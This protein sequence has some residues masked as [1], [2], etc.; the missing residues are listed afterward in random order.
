[1]HYIEVP[2]TS[3]AL[4]ADGDAQGYVTV[5]SNANFYPGATAWLTSNT[6]P[7]KYCKI[8]DLSGAT[9]I[10]LRF[11]NE[12]T[13]SGAFVGPS[14]IRN[15]CAAYLVADGARIDMEASVVPVEAS[16]SKKAAI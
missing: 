7:A 3:A 14:Y 8:T 4:S 2:A 6:Q 15:S 16:F 13:T 1:M 11:I 9:K 12:K 5:A 10:G